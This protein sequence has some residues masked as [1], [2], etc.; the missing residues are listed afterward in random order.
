MLS[1]AQNPHRSPSLKS[2]LEAFRAAFMTKAPEEVR[3]IMARADADLAASGILDRALKAGDTAP[4]FDLPDAR[5][6]RFRLADALRD[7]P[8][9]LSFYRGGWCPYCNLELKAL[10]RALADFERLGAQL[11]AV[12]PQT[13]DHSLSTAEKNALTFPVLSDLGSKTAKAFGVAFDLDKNLQTLYAR[14]GHALPEVNGDGGWTLPIPATFVIDTSGVVAFAY[15]DVDYRSRLEPQ[16]ITD[17]LA[18]LARRRV[19]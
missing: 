4:D 13:P 7:G 19:A 2:E 11:V 12:S 14:F 17:T 18:A 10:Q 8:V 1:S 15:V 9:V 6:D 5:G 3:A 16:A